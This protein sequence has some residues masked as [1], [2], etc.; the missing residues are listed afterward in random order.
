MAA[1]I[2]AAV[3]AITLSSYIA[4]SLNSLKIANRSFYLNAA[5]NLE[6]TGM[7]HALW[8]LNNLKDLGAAAWT[9]GGFAS[10]AGGYQGTFG[11]FSLMGGATGTVKVWVEDP[12]P[13]IAN[14]DLV[15]GP[16]AVAQSTVILPNS[17]PI[18][19]VA[20]L[21]LAQA[22]LWSGGMV[23]RNGM[24]F[25]GNAR[26]D[27]WKSR[28]NPGDDI[29]Y[30]I[31]PARA[32]AQ[33]SSPNL[34][35]AATADIFGY[36]AIGTSNNSGFSYNA[37][38]A[39]LSGDL[40]ASRGTVD[41]TRITNNFTGDFP[42]VDAPT[43]T[44]ISAI[45]V[46]GGG[47]PSAAAISMT[48]SGTYTL[49]SI[50]FSGNADGLVIGTTGATPINA[51]VVLVV[52]GDLRVTGTANIIINPGSSLTLYVAGDVD[53]TG[54]GGFQNGTASAPNNPDRLTIY[55]T[56]PSSS[57][58]NIPADWQDWSLTGNGYLSAVI[59]APNADVTVNGGAN[60]YGSIVGEYVTMVGGG[61]F[62]QDESLG[63]KKTSGL[64]RLSK[65]RE[66]TTAAER[67]STTITTP[68]NF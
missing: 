68:L 5:Q 39:T 64:W 60:I 65:W 46:A 43:G 24:R 54:S 34:I 31:G 3:I 16:R 14:P 23:S 6:D 25:T 22:S 33:I 35:A 40:L 55:G 15:G 18:T 50:S 59:W 12:A 52:T 26:V 53:M 9:T 27:S 42:D 56:K 30:A 2:F 45:N 51:D 28:P 49:S 17:A 48:T 19:K 47:G 62:H 10:G 67:A 36:I 29:S 58:I 11:P 4:L 20:E 21:Y 57:I 63:R 1:L 32:N 38:Q 8:S 66:I 37:A 41:P 61:A 13:W 44:P 7:E